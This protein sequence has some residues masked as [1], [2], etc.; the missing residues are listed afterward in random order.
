M[1]IYIHKPIYYILWMINHNFGFSFACK[2]WQR[3]QRQ[4]RQRCQ[5]RQRWPCVAHGAQR[6]RRHGMVKCGAWRGR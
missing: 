4:Q 6:S 3:R 1:Y 2:G 5:H